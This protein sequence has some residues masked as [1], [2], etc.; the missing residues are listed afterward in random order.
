MNFYDQVNPFNY[1]MTLED[2]ETLI[3]IKYCPVM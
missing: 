2:F 1:G 3:Q